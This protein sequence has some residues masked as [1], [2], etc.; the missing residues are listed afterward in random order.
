MHSNVLEEQDLRVD[1]QKEVMKVYVSL[2]P[3]QPSIQ[4][5]VRL[6]T[7]PSIRIYPQALHSVFL[8]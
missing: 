5:F 2:H 8:C 3:P 4:P 7:H 6:S 1:Q